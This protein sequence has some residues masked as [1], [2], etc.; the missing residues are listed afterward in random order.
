[1]VHR[2][3]HDFTAPQGP[4]APRVL[5]A[6]GDAALRGRFKKLGERAGWVCETVDG[7][8]SAL[9][10]VDQ[11][12]FDIIVTDLVLPDMTPH[13]VLHRFNA[14][15]GNDLTPLVIV[16]DST[17]A[18]SD[19]AELIREGAADVLPASADL[20]TISRSIDRIYRGSSNDEG[21][22]WGYRFVAI[23]R[24][25]WVLTAAQLAAIGK[26]PLYI[27]DRLYRAGRIN[28]DL[29]RRLDVA[30][31]EAIMNALEHG[32]LELDSAWREEF[33]ASGVDRY[34]IVRAAR[35]TEPHYAG[36]TITIDTALEKTLLMIR[37]ADEG[38]GFDPTAKKTPSSVTLCS[39]R[40]LAIITWSV[41]QVRYS[42]DGT[43]ITLVKNLSG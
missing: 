39:G 1:M 22:S 37:I 31:H 6:D 24:G 9:S 20:A 11:K 3:H 14:V 30:F 12:Q 18:W 38:K 8:S 16:V 2:R 33:D 17:G 15:T 42:S 10:A 32:C 4:A 28:R 29:K 40:G 34:S 25:T 41:D 7:V 36:R 27:A 21:T 19:P 26:F 13:E 35:L 43:E 23:E 5:F